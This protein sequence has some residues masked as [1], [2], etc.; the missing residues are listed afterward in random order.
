LSVLVNHSF[1]QALA[2]G[3]SGVDIF[4]VISGY[5]IGRHLLQDIAASRF[6]FLGFY[7]KRARRIFPALALVLLSVGG[8]GWFVLSAGEFSALGWHIAASS[9]FANNIALWTESGYFDAAALDKPLLHLWSLG[10]EEQ[11]YLLVPALL[12]LGITGS[13]GSIRWVARLAALSFMATI[14]LGTSDYA[15]SF[16]LLHT[17][18]WEMGAGVMLAQAELR[19][20]SRSS[21]EIRKASK[22]DV[23]EIT[24]WCAV[25]ALAAVVV[26]GASE[27]RSLRHPWMDNSALGLAIAI[28]A[29]T[30]FF[31][32]RRN[33]KSAWDRVVEF[34]V[35]NRSRIDAGTSIVGITLI[36]ISVTAPSSTEWPDARTLF[37]VLGTLLVIASTPSAG[38]NRLLST[39]PLAF[40]GGISYPLYLW[41]WPAIVF[42]RLLH[43]DAKGVAIAIPLVI[44]F[45]L[46]WLT[47]V[48]LETPVRFGRLG[49][50]TFPRPPLWPAVG[51]LAVIGL[52]GG[53]LVAADGLPYRFPPT[54]RAIAEWSEVKPDINWRVGICYFYTDAKMD[55]SSE[56]T[57]KKRPGVPRILLWGDSHAAQL[58]PGLAQLQKSNVFDI[59]QWTAA[60]CPPTIEPIK[61]ETPGC[62]MR[63]AA[64][65]TRLL[66]LKPDMVLLGGGWGR[67]LES[68]ET[69]EK[70][71]TLLSATVRRLKDLGIQRIA[72]FGPGP[73][74]QTTL[75]NDLFRFMAAHRLDEIPTRF[76]TVS[77]A[78]WRLDSAIAALAT[79][80]MVQYVSTLRYFCDSSGCLTVNDRSLPRPDLLYRDQDHLTV[81]GSRVLI[82]HSNLRIF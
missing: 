23:R 58:Y 24:M 57:P 4:F 32:D 64:A 59:V 78:L 77:D 72:I 55:F 68:G 31:A 11:F 80:E 71:L 45:A 6:T 20:V 52:L 30:A 22:N 3:F 70:I 9:L 54:L 48:L 74:F 18:F 15:A 36:C 67:Y 79:I 66:E 13:R 47:K 7:A 73:L 38:L 40:V 34:Y 8:V 28:A 56:C 76:G 27:Q 49:P 25:L 46:A 37:P 41:H 50:R 63:R 26:L 81:S 19:F 35:R 61:Q 65:W 14:V 16:Y 51:V 82:E 2:G 21:L 53:W 1:P 33:N 75:P 5:L 43:P 44:A 10:I 39:R 29:S 60:G 42:F 12:W 62:A 69:Q 17:R